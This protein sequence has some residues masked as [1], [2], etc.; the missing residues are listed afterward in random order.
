MN[1]DELKAKLESSGVRLDAYSLNGPSDEAY[2]LESSGTG[3]VVYY[4][5]RGI[6]SGKKTFG[7]EAEACEYFA[8][9]VL[10]DSSLQ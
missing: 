8:A 10:T 5:E 6:E 9:T 7:S 3:W 4:S 2:C 1:R